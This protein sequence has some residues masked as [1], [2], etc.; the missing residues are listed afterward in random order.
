MDGSSGGESAAKRPSPG[1]LSVRE[2]SDHDLR[3]AMEL[4]DEYVGVGRARFEAWRT[5]RPSWL[6][7]AYL[8][9]EL[10]GVCLGNEKLPGAVVLQ[11]IGVVFDHWGKGIGSALLRDFEE[12]LAADG[13]VSVSLGSAPDEATESFYRKNGYRATH[14]M[15]KLSPEAESPIKASRRPEGLRQDD[16][17]RRL[18]VEIADYDRALRDKL[19]DEYRAEEAIFI[20]EKNLA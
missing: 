3:R 2:V 13:M 15:M 17:G 8:G 14:V 6:R 12:T 20:F 11:T 5:E 10:V 9:S 7:G 19:R 16:R 18:V 1:G 4:D